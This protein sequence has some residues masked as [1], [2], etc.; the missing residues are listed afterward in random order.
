MI[1]TIAVL[2]FTFIDYWTKW[3]MW[4]FICSILVGLF[5]FLWPYAF[6]II[7]V[8]WF[9]ILTHH[10][11]KNRN[12][13]LRATGEN[14]KIDIS[15]KHLNE[16]LSIIEKRL[17]EEINKKGVSFDNKLKLL[18]SKLDRKILEIES[19]L[20]NFEIEDHLNK[21]QVGAMS[22]MIKKLNIDIK[23][24]FGE[25]DT[26]FEIKEYIKDKGMPHFYLPDLTNTLAK[27]PDGFKFLKEDILKLAQEK[28]YKVN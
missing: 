17:N 25:E 28:L 2:F 7:T 4:A 12:K 1:L 18:E 24:G 26:L 15:E 6:E 9:V 8:V 22:Q 5:M 21:K 3:K 19:S 11:F 14:E 16:K 10:V 27:V 23:R 20:V 13:N